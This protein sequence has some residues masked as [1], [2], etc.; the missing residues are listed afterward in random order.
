MNWYLKHIAGARKKALHL[1]DDTLALMDNPRFPCPPG[2]LEAQVLCT[3]PYFSFDGATHIG[4]L[5]VHRDLVK[6]VQ[7]IFSELLRWRFP[8]WSIV[9][10][11]A[12]GWNDEYSMAAN[13]TSAFNYRT[14]V[15]REK[16]SLHA[17]GRAIDI[18]PRQ[19]PCRSQGRWSP[20]G[21]RYD[22][23][24][25]GTITADSF[26]VST[27][28]SRGFFWGGDWQEPFDPQHFYKPL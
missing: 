10:I 26:V 17:Y 3:V 25:P 11:V 27:F 22:S 14:I 20:S 16:L 4:Q 24:L 21:A 18:N 15:G 8:I 9:P 12:Y 6:D 7:W 5:V 19:N 28:R 13:N 1:L 23:A 2:I